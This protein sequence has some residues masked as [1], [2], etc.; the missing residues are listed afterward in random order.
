MERSL[1]ASCN[2]SGVLRWFRMFLFLLLLGLL[3]IAVVTR[4]IEVFDFKAK[5]SSDLLELIKSI[6]G[7]LLTIAGPML[8]L[9][10][11][12]PLPGHCCSLLLWM[13]KTPMDAQ[14]IPTDAQECLYSYACS[15]MSRS[16][17][18]IFHHRPPSATI[19]HP[20]DIHR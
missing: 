1:L 12:G 2:F 9:S 8:A 15:G 13:H 19:G 16:G 5:W 4:S 7:P 10:T 17:M 14:D 3:A 6:A 18:S 20:L 11:A